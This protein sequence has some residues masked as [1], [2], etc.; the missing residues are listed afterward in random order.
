MSNA[1]ESKDMQLAPSPEARTP[2]G[3]TW[4]YASEEARETL[5]WRAELLLD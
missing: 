1:F 4:S 5:H 3:T 2:D